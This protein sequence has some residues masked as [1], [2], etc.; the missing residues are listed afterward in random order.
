MNRRKVLAAVT[1]AAILSFPA[2]TTEIKALH[3]M[4]AAQWTYF[5]EMDAEEALIVGVGG[6]VMCSFIPGIGS[7]ACGVAGAF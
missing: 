6:A 4:P 7:V 2:A 1:L 3:G 5:L